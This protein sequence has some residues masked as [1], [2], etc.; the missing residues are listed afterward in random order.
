MPPFLVFL[1]GLGLAILIVAL[2]EDA[3]A[4]DAD[5]DEWTAFLLS[6]PEL[7]V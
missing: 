2:F 6:H 5:L 1:V 3:P 4:A 7:R